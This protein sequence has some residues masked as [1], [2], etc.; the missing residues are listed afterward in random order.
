MREP[1]WR[2]VEVRIGSHQ[3]EIVAERLWSLGCQAIEEVDVSPSRSQVPEIALRT[4]LGH[5]A[6][7]NLKMLEQEFPDA[8]VTE[9]EIPRAVSETWR[10]HVVATE[11]TPDLLVVPAWLDVP[12]GPTTIRIEPVDAFGL[13][14]HPTTILAARLILDHVVHDDHVLDVGCGSGVLALV[15]AVMR[16][17]R[18]VA[19]DVVA[20]CREVVQKNC[21]L[22]RVEPGV[23][24]WAGEIDGLNDDC[25]GVVVANILAPVLR[26]IASTLQRVVRPG[27]LIILSGLLDTQ[28]EYVLGAY[29][30]WTI[31]ESLQLDARQDSKWTAVAL[32]RG[33]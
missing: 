1:V 9:V 26:E 25:F 4:H 27:G 17:A 7:R 20:S 19:T 33:E 16:G 8:V 6:R 31:L 10:S 3:A 30:G 22:N 28:V 15:A 11:I 32:R 14:D 12:P 5:S 2:L 23:I 24:T 13:G 21:R 18:C 29:P